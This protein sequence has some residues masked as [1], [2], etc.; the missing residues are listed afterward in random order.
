MFEKALSFAG[1]FNLRFPAIIQAPMAGGLTTPGF[2][3]AVSNHQGLGS[4]AT[5]YL[6]ATQVQDAIT[7]IKKST[8]K[9]FAV[10]LFIPPQKVNFDSV[11]IVKY[12][13]KLNQ[14]RRELKLQEEDSG[15]P[16]YLPSDHF[17]EIVEIVLAEKIKMVSFTFGMLSQDYVQKFKRENV[18]LIGT[19]T[20]LAEAQAL[21]RLGINAIVAQGSEAGGHRGGFF[22]NQMLKTHELVKLISEQCEVPIIASGGI[23]NAKHILS[24]L[25]YGASAVQMGTA[26]IPLAESGAN[27]SFKSAILEAQKTKKT[28]PTTITSHYSGKPARG[29]W[30]RFIR[31]MLDDN[32][33]VPDYPIPHYLT[34][35]I[36][37][38]AAKQDNRDLMSL[39]CGEGIHDLDPNN[40]TIEQLLTSLWASVEQELAEKS[41]SIRRRCKRQLR[42]QCRPERR[43]AVSRC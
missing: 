24:A 17:E 3:S 38:E 22:D 37:K 19:A 2:V 32:V 21:Q 12:Q 7:S 31:E 43:P 14:Y 40:K 13:E 36:R 25:E 27:V 29:L 42:H 20:S 23:M 35:G 6:N 33:Q 39:W 9:P 28:N 11:K 10:N 1:A 16:P 41:E 18:Y 8:D 30:T 4:F 5:G 15:Q 26:F 34:Q